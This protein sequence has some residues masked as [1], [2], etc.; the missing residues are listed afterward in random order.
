MCVVNVCCR[1]HV[2]PEFSLW[3]Q[4]VS[5]IDG[6][7]EQEVASASGHPYDFEPPATSSLSSS[8]HRSETH[9]A[10]N[11]LMTRNS[12]SFEM[13]SSSEEIGSSELSVPAHSDPST[14]GLSCPT[15]STD[16]QVSSLSE[17]QQPEV[18]PSR[19]AVDR[20]M[21][22]GRPAENNVP[23]LAKTSDAQSVESRND[24]NLTYVVSA[25]SECS[26]VLSSQSVTSASDQII[27]SSA[28]S[29]SADL[30]A[31]NI[32]P[33]DTAVAC[34]SSGAHQP[35]AGNGQPLLA[36]ASSE[37][38][39]TEHIQSSPSKSP[40]VCVVFLTCYVCLFI[41]FMVIFPSVL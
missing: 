13:M 38:L 15:N 16:V 28:S 31:V 18:N 11:Q 39:S 19:S 5:N 17:T 21:S 40:V 34:T 4:N 9:T 14:V 10:D 37:S 23:S 27:V 22:N 33:M 24:R 2:E 30:D 1:H 6:V 26:V 29:S 7:V 25:P 32:E 36:D 20:P 3:K 8:M 12:E 35:V 41:V